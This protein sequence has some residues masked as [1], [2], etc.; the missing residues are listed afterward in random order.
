[1]VFLSMVHGPVLEGTRVRSI[2]LVE[3]LDNEPTRL[4]EYLACVQLRLSPRILRA[5]YPR[6]L[7]TLLA[8]S[9]LFSCAPAAITLL[10]AMYENSKLAQVSTYI[11]ILRFALNI[12]VGL[13]LCST[14][15]MAKVFFGVLTTWAIIWYFMQVRGGRVTSTNQKLR[16]YPPGMSCARQEAVMEA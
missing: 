15:P 9:V 16:S 1:M 10:A 7:P 14:E 5:G 4:H 13:V 8:T 2:I 12:W 11:W 3:G 6:S